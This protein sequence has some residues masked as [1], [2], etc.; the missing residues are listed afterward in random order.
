MDPDPTDRTTVDAASMSG[1]ES[2]GEFGV[3]AVLRVL[4]CRFGDGS[5]YM[6]EVTDKPV[7]RAAQALGLISGDG[8]LTRAGRR[9]LSTHGRD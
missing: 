1:A 9:F 4:A 2:W 3:E 7:Y 5:V 6:E 8:Y